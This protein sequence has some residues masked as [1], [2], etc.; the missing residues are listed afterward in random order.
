MTA[1]VSAKVVQSTL[2]GALRAASGIED[3]ADRA[4]VLARTAAL[5]HR[6]DDESGAATCVSLAHAFARRIPEGAMRGSALG[7]I[8]RA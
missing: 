2:A 8:A 1:I 3:R 7:C 4:T 6:A 5:L